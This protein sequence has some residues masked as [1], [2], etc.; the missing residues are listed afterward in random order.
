MRKILIMMCGIPASGKSTVAYDLAKRLEEQKSIIVSMDS[1]REEWFGTRKC[2]DRGDEVYAQSVE[3]TLW[4]FE[5]FN[6]VI[7]DATNRTKKA[8]KQLVK[9][10]Q[11]YYDCIVYCVYMGTPLEIALERN[12]KRDESIQVPPEA[13]RRMYNS[14]QP[15]TKK[16]KYFKEIY[17]IIEPKLFDIYREMWYNMF[18]NLVKG[19]LKQ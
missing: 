4:A 7:Y 9:T 8:R 17:C 3:D 10:I 1:I 16:E 5:N 13:I 6:V 12:T 2:Q 14:L 15:P 18:T 19:D 11:K